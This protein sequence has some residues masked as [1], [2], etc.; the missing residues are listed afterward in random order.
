MKNQLGNITLSASLAGFGLCKF[1]L[2]ATQGLPPVALDGMA[3]VFE[4]A[5]V[6]GVADWFAVTILFHRPFK[7]PVKPVL[8]KARREIEANI[9]SFIQEF[10]PPEKISEFIRDF[11]PSAQLLTLLRNPDV[12]AVIKGY[13]QVHGS[14]ALVSTSADGWITRTVAKTEEVLREGRVNIGAFVGKLANDNLPLI[15]DELIKLGRPI[16]QDLEAKVT[17]SGTPAQ[18]ALKS[19]A[20][21]VLMHLMKS[22]LETAVLEPLMTDLSRSVVKL[23]NDARLQQDLSETIYERLAANGAFKLMEERLRDALKAA[24][25]DLGEDEGRLPALVEV[26]VD[27]MERLLSDPG[28]Q[29]KFDETCTSLAANFVSA[30]LT[31]TLGGLIQS[32]MAEISD[33]VFL[34]KLEDRVYGEL[35]MVRLNGALMGGFA[36]GLLFL[37]TRFLGS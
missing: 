25:A 27:L 34:G 33:Q 5:T 23:A 31:H 6:G 3:H 30:N 29:R 17:T 7:L 26:M 4:A 32:Q 10:L 22:D 20:K 24:A 16:I 37:A 12:K 8:L 14:A 21:A 1:V 2:P 13:V 28:F 19:G 11:K 36:G 18:A 15:R 9:T 35:Q